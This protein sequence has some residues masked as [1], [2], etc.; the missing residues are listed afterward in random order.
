MKTL[1][2]YYSAR[3]LREIDEDNT[4]QIIKATSVRIS[5]RT[6]LQTFAL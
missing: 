2:I 4:K 5:V 1:F 6:A 3:L